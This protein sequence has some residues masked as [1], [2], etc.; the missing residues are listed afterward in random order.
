M[1]PRRVGL[2][3]ALMIHGLLPGASGAE[4]RRGGRS[5]HARSGS[6]VR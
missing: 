3:I 1:S 2:P 6:T 4:P 5:V